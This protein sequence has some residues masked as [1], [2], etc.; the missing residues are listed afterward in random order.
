MAKLLQNSLYG[1]FGRIP[2]L[3]EFKNVFNHE[4]PAYLV[5]RIVNNI[6]EINDEVSAINMS[7]NINHET[8]NMLNSTLN[9]NIKI[10]YLPV[11]TNVAVASA[12]TAYGR[13]EM[14]DFKLDDG[15]IYSDT[16]SILTTNTLHENFIGKELGQVKD[17]LNGKSMDKCLVLG[18]KEYGYTYLEEDGS[19]I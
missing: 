10:K 18:I 4:I 5:T 16:D 13:I 3:N 19:L 6:V 15:V 12:V 8:L 11:K 1:F 2:I 14:M 17:E 7:C 9:T